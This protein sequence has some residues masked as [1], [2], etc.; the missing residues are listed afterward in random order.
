M[1]KIEITIK[2]VVTIDMQVRYF[3]VADEDHLEFVKELITRG[4]KEKNLEVAFN[5]EPL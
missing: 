4:G 1:A 3:F 5:Q 2:K